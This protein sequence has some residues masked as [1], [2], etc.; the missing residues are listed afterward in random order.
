MK[1]IFALAM[2]TI[3]ISIFLTGCKKDK[4]NPPTLPPQESMTI[5]FANFTTGKSG[6]ALSQKGVNDYYWAFSALVAGYFKGYIVGALAVP[7]ASFRLAID[8]KPSYVEELTWQWSYSV[9]VASITYKARLVG[10]IGTTDVVWKMYI[11][12]EGTGGY[13]EFIWF[14][15]TSKIDGTGG[16]WT[17]KQSNAEQVPVLKIDWT[18]TG[19]TIGTVTYTF[20]KS[21]DPFNS[22]SIKYGKQTGMYDAYYTIRYFNGS[23]FSD[24]DVQWSTAGRNGTVKCLV[25]FG[26]NSYHCWDGNYVDLATCP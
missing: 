24:V 22:S 10:Q 5:D 1:K 20:I 14:E 3:F 15:G 2:L 18:R 11:S 26:D 19:T 8:Q 17:L 25:F 6:D 21:G 4:G 12:K 13:A 16:T 23:S 7:V 9:T